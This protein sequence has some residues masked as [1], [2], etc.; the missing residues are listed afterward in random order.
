MDSCT[1]HP[2]EQGAGLCQ[3]CGMAWCQ[4]CLVFAFGPKKPPFCVEC[5]MFAG[6]VRSAAPRPAMHRRE[7]KARMKAMKLAGK[8]P[9]D[10]PAAFAAE[11]DEVGVTP[12]LPS[13]DWERPWWEDRP[14]D[15][16]EPTLTD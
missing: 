1:K 16:R 9:A 5:A 12:A 2:H 8:R 13:S 11:P 6:G 3:R 10:V 14:A 15:D 7:L 4:E